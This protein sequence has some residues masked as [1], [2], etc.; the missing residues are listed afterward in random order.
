[1]PQGL[2]P[3]RI[4]LKL[5]DLETAGTAAWKGE[6]P[7]T[8]PL[9]TRDKRRCVTMAGVVFELTIPSFEWTKIFHAL[10]RTATVNVSW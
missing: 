4:N 1:M 9:R 2:F 8:R 7:I 6:V 5:G 3:F 10:G